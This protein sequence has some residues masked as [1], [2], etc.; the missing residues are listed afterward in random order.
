MLSNNPGPRG[1]RNHERARSITV[2]NPSGMKPFPFN[3]LSRRIGLLLVSSKENKRASRDRGKLR[4]ELLVLNNRT[5]EVPW[6]QCKR[7]GWLG[8]T[9]RRGSNNRRSRAPRRGSRGSRNRDLSRRGR[10]L[11]LRFC[12]GCGLRLGLGLSTWPG[13]LIWGLLRKQRAQGRQQRLEPRRTLAHK[14][15]QNSLKQRK[16]LCLASLGALAPSDSRGA[17]PRMGGF[18]NPLTQQSNGAV[19]AVA[20]KAVPSSACHRNPGT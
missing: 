18:A 8:P 16:Q 17:R 12:L 2:E 9:L 5:M 7:R 4:R 3:K 13:R 14:Q 15:L 20:R 11:G 19:E 6:P 10:R 1:K